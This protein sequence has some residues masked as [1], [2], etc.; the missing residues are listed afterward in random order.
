MI[1]DLNSLIA[2]TVR[3]ILGIAR[4]TLQEEGSHL[5]T[6]ILHT[7]RGMMPIVLP[8]KNDEQ[9]RALVKQVKKQALEKGAYAVTTITCGRIVDSRTGQEQESLIVATAIQ[10]GRPHMVV[11]PYS[12]DADRRVVGFGETIEGERAAMPGQMMIL[13]DWDEEVS[14]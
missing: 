14:H 10:R 2:E 4:R 11:Q 6:A 3:V 12:R 1:I 9:K 8:F 13:P 5:P 7:M